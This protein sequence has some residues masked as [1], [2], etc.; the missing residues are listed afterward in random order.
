MFKKFCGYMLGVSINFYLLIETKLY[1]CQ[2]LSEYLCQYNQKIYAVSLQSV[3]YHPFIFLDPY[4]LPAGD[5][6]DLLRNGGVFIMI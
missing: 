2:K 3:L 5:L 1:K 4:F 6:T